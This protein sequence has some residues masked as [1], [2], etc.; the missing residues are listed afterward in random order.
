MHPQSFCKQ[1]DPE[2]RARRADCWG[3]ES[4]PHLPTQG[5]AQESFIRALLLLP[6]PDTWA[7]SPGRL[8]AFPTATPPP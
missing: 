3:L 4:G 1:G 2:H 7:G 5:K 8:G 6:P